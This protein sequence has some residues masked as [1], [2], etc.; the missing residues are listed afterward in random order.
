MLTNAQIAQAKATTS[1]GGAAPVAPGQAMTPEQFQGW[2]GSPTNSTSGGYTSQVTKNLGE[3]FTQGAAN[4]TKDV[5]DIPR[6]AN[7]VTNP[8]PIAAAAGHVAGDI[9][10]TAGGM[11]GSFL[12]PLL[13]EDTKS[14]LAGGIDTISH[15][16]NSIPGM[17]PEIAKSLGDVFNTATL[18]GGARAVPKVTGA[19]SEVKTALTP[20]AETPESIVARQ[21]AS[22][23]SRKA[24]LANEVKNVAAEWKQPT[25]P[26]KSTNPA[27][28]NK[29]RE[30]LANSPGTPKFLAE[31]KL[32]PAEHTENGRYAT[33]DS[34]T[35]MRDTAGKLSADVLRP[36]LK[37]AENVTP[38]TSVDEIRRAAIANVARDPLITGGNRQ[39]VIKNINHEADI[40]Q[41]DYPQGMKLTDMHDKKIAHA[42]DGGYKPNGSVAD[43]NIATAHRNLSSALGDMVEAKAPPELDVGRANDYFSKYYKAADYL[44]AID[45]KK[46]PVSLTQSM[47]HRGAQLFGAITGHGMS[48]GL[49]GGA[50]GYSI[51][52]SLEHA[53]ENMTVPMR[54]SFLKNL[55]V[56]HPEAVT[57]ITEYL[58]NESAARSTRLA[59]PPP[60]TIALPAAK[61]ESSVTSVAATKNPVLVDPKTGK[62]QTSYS[63]TPQRQGEMPLISQYT[64]DTKN[65]MASKNNPID[66][67][68]APTDGSV[69]PPHTSESG[70]IKNPFARAPEQAP[71][72]IAEAD[73][74]K[75]NEMIDRHATTMQQAITANKVPPEGMPDAFQNMKN[76]VMLGVGKEPGNSAE[77]VLKALQNVNPK[78]YSS[79]EDFTRALKDTMEAKAYNIPGTAI[80]R[81][82]QPGNY[83][84]FKKETAQRYGDDVSEAKLPDKTLDLFSPGTGDQALADQVHAHGIKLYKQMGKIPNDE[85][86]YQP[87]W[88]KG[89]NAILLRDDRT[90]ELNVLLNPNRAK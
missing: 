9:A 87:V 71:G 38:P 32:H 58:K 48:G 34:A 43:D 10:G 51:G 49:L 23:A 77:G 37:E 13:S 18:L 14:R 70:F 40:L 42:S 82:G 86:S 41:E 5:T 62:L 22:Q 16:V 78:D 19:A 36:G 80:Y 90:G 50:I 69:N 35:A 73:L 45:N 57:K 89:Y 83:Y 24:S 85:M 1:T 20:A 25:I 76:N 65:A 46:V 47:L 17:T 53:L 29:G 4:V 84:S 55:Q 21:A 31:Q 59:L 64:S 26:G 11:L 39:S 7:L 66:P 28:F 56:T 67:N 52:G 61:G 27:S 3:T 2:M 54:A 79:L 63:S 72:T 74:P 6:D 30:I 68:V 44:E 75:M 81:G 12:M 60:S 88:D 15:K 33:K 8:L